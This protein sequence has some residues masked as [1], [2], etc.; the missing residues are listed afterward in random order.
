MRKN[1]FKTTYLSCSFISACPN[2][3]SRAKIQPLQTEVGST[4]E[5]F[6]Y[7]LK[8]IKLDKKIKLFSLFCTRLITE[9]N[10]CQSC[11]VFAH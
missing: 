6:L 7:S 9:D 10:S 5:I 8:R 4:A 1:V 3:L 2:G 11:S